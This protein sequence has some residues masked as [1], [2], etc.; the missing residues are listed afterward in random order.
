MYLIN[1]TRYRPTVSLDSWKIPVGQN[2]YFA[3]TR[4]CKQDTKGQYLRI[5]S[6]LYLYIFLFLYLQTRFNRHSIDQQ[7]YACDQWSVTY[8]VQMYTT[9]KYTTVYTQCFTA[10][11]DQLP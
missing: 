10:V 11:T 9:S 7:T 1:K 4:E 5:L 6:K 3:V 8:E 2:V